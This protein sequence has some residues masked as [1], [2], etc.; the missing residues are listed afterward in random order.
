MYLLP[1]NFY[2]HSTIEGVSLISLEFFE[3]TITVH[4][5]KHTKVGAKKGKREENHVPEKGVSLEGSHLE[6]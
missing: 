4:V 1:K 6:R 2:S 5:Q 3:I